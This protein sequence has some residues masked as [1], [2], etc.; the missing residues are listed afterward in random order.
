M[1]FF[2][3]RN[4][5]PRT[6]IDNHSPKNER[7]VELLSVP[8][9]APAPPLLERLAYRSTSD[10]TSGVL[11]ST[12]G[13]FRAAEP[14]SNATAAITV[15][16]SSATFTAGHRDISRAV[17]NVVVSVRVEERNEVRRRR[18]SIESQKCETYGQFGDDLNAF[19]SR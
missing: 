12:A 11:P 14:Q 8:V 3:K 10:S 15:V 4:V 16:L 9:D 5:E 6:D 2:V 7:R 19:R 1:N 13:R 18:R 17:G